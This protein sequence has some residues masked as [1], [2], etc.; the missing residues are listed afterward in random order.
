MLKKTDARIPAQQKFCPVCGSVNLK[1]VET[2]ALIHSGTFQMY[3]CADC[4]Y[5]G[6]IVIGGLNMQEQ[7]KKNYA[8]R[9]A[10][11]VNG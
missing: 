5:E 4:G 6:P 11:D 2:P 1:I 10:G 9:K 7:L 3:K 8:E